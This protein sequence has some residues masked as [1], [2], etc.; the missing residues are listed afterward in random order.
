MPTSQIQF[1]ISYMDTDVLS[2]GFARLLSAGHFVMPHMSS[3]LLLAFCVC[4]AAVGCTGRDASSRA[5]DDQFDASKGTFVNLATAVPG[6]WEKVC[7]LGPYSNNE[8]AQKTLGFEWSVETKSSIT[9]NEGI[10]LLLFVQENM[11]TSYVEHPRNH[12]DF[13]N[14]TAQCFPKAKAQYVHDPKPT[15]GWPGLFQRNVA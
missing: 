4:L 7:V 3:R 6:D 15:R 10:S 1:N 2:A 14:L 13:S 5:I 12:G 11:V 9:T 8:T